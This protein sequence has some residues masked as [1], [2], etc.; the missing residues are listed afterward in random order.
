MSERVERFRQRRAILDTRVGD[1]PPLIA[2][3]ELVQ[4]ILHQEIDWSM[5]DS[6]AIKVPVFNDVVVTDEDVDR[7]LSDLDRAFTRQKYDALFEGVK[8]TLIDQILT[9]LKLS[10]SDLMQTDRKFVYED[11]KYEY[12]K[13]FD[14]TRKKI[15]E[16]TT[17]SDGTTTD[18]Y[19]GERH[20]S[21]EKMEADHVRSLKE[22]HEKGGFMLDSEEKEALGNDQDNLVFTKRKINR[23]KGD[24]PLEDQGLDGRRTRHIKKKADKSVEKQIPK[25]LDFARRAARDGIKTG[26]K[27]GQQQALAFIISELIAAIFAEVKDVFENGWKGGDYN[28]SWLGSLKKRLKRVGRYLLNRWKGVAESFGTGWLAGFLSATTTALFNM[29]VRTSK[30]IVRIIREG[31]VSIMEALKLLLFPPEGMSLRQAAHEATKVFAT[32]LVVTGGIMA[33]DKIANSLP[34]LGSILGPVFGGLISGL[35]SLFVTFML[36][37]LD[38]FGVNFD[39]RHDFIM[40][41]LKNRISDAARE[42]EDIEANLE[43]IIF[44]PPPTG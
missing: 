42:I 17:N 15:K 19:T 5:I 41:T 18:R 36:D 24:R 27:Q 25:S 14:S 7:C 40:G 26:N 4:D 8:D 1:I 30:N 33:G 29:F 12:R 39:E 3:A 38:L 44:A 43:R 32:G 34:M 31:F 21:N 22:L 13:G 9:P 35:G 37:K 28:A 6:V 23:K 20:D 2:D 10:R 16:K 11:V